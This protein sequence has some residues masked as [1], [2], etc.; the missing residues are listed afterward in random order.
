MSSICTAFQ[1]EVEALDVRDEDYGV[2]LRRLT[3]KLAKDASAHVA[4]Y[5][6][7]EISAL[8]QRSHEVLS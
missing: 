2:Y 4:D 7:G 5:H 3:L 6:F 8:L 1:A